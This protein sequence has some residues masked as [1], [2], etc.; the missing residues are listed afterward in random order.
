MTLSWK[1]GLSR[2]QMDEALIRRSQ[3]QY[4]EGL[5]SIGEYWTSSPSLAVLSIFEADSY[6]SIMEVGFFWGDVFDIQTVPA[7]TAEEGLRMGQAIME[8]RPQ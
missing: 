3:W 8:R 2:E 5:T 4:P 6:E 7:T 1:P